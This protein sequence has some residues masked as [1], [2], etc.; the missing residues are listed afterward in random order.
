[1]TNKRYLEILIS[2]YIDKNK[3]TKNLKEFLYKINNKKTVS[4][5]NYP[6]NI[7][8]NQ[9]GI[10]NFLVISYFVFIF[11]LA[12]ILISLCIY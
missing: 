2:S 1:M 10:S 7:I 4:L 9:H 11:E 6:Q 3:E 12:F 8:F 5:K